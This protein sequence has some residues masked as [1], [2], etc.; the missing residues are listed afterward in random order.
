MNLFRRPPAL[1]THSY[2]G[3]EWSRYPRSRHASQRR[4]FRRYLG[5]G[6]GVVL[7]HRAMWEDA[8]GPIPKGFQVH[9]VNRDHN[10]NEL[11]N[12]ELVGF[13]EHN[14]QHPERA[15]RIRRYAG[16][17]TFPV[18]MKRRLR[19]AGERLGLLEPR[20]RRRKRR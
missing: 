18:R 9:H 16:R 3:H 5:K 12:F 7:L 4:Y 10:R 6:K 17:G 1:E 15:L 13:A 8:R 14:A 2:G 20:R 11:A 19:R